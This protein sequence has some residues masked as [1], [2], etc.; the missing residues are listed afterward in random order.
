MRNDHAH[1]ARAVFAG[2]LL[3]LLPALAAPVAADYD[4]AGEGTAGYDTAY[5]Y[6]RVL[7]GSATLIQGAG[8]G[9]AAERA[10]AEIN[11]PV[12]AGDRL[13]VAPGS[14][15]EVLLSDRNLLRLDGESEAAFE[16]LAFSPES[17][18]RVTTLRLLRGNAQLVV[19]AD[20][21]GDQLPRFD[22]PNATIYPQDFGVYRVT[23][24]GGDWTEVVVRRGR[25]EVVTGPEAL[26]VSADQR[27]LVEGTGRPWTDVRAAGGYDPLERWAADLDRGAREY[28]S[29]YVDD[30]LRYAAGP[31]E[32]Y[33]RWV[34]VGGSSAWYPRVDAGWRPY[35]HGR[36]SHTPA[37][38]IWISS[39]PWGWVPYHYGTWDYAPGYGWVWFPGRRFA[40]AWVYWHWGS[41]HVAWVPVGYYT[42]HYRFNH[43]YPGFRSGVYGWAG[44]DWGFFSD[45]VFCDRVFFGGRHSSRHFFRGHDG[46]RR[47][48]GQAVP[49]GILTTDTRPLRPDLWRDGDEALRVL[50]TRP[51]SGGRVAVAEELPDVTPFV[52]RR[53]GDLPAEV[54][55]RIAI[56]RGEVDRVAGTPLAPGTQAPERGLAVPRA[57][58]PR[59]GVRSEGSGEVRRVDTDPGRALAV[60]RGEPRA[61][62]ARPKTE[63]GREPE[64]DRSGRDAGRAVAVPRGEAPRGE[65]PPGDEAGKPAPRAARPS[66]G[67][68]DGDKPQGEA[69]RAVRPRT[70]GS[71]DDNPQGAAPRAVRP[72]DGDGDDGK[73]RDE[74]SPRAAP[75]AANPGVVS[76]G[77][78]AVPRATAR[79][80]GQ[81][82]DGLARRAPRP[83]APATAGAG[84]SDAEL[85]RVPEAG[86]PASRPPAPTV[87]SSARRAPAPTARSDAPRSAPMV[88]PSERRA[89]APTVRPYVSRSAPT[90]QP[91]ERRAPAPTARPYVS[92][93][94]PTAQPP[95]SRAPAPTVRPTA[96]RTAPSARQPAARPPA[97]RASAP[98][99]GDGRT[100]APR[101]EAAPSRGES[102]GG[103]AARRDRGGS[104]GAARSRGDRG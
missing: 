50:R 94:A 97:P 38:L 17:G 1:D 27:A 54:E 43:G 85:R 29:P 7:D 78:T 86:R 70:G 90:V 57:A 15:A 4:A 24:D 77:R 88:Q 16:S 44:G 20:S 104:G 18:D 53:G 62:A 68:P 51:G 103:G 39:E 11:Q 82:G 10:Q 37:G 69:P 72:R 19:T 66:A 64:A 5:S 28:D 41:S 67:S 3:L 92:R 83:A 26:T 30:D 76:L 79:G 14:R 93:S 22:T 47:H 34:D 74:A 9:E 101:A 61:P 81:D 21:L 60:T 48:G 95:G 75:R 49:R 96:P 12:L 35:W 6:L 42:R 52:A 98:S 87:G 84:R 40:P 31:L 33:G 36:W 89:P 71:D 99:G 2:A 8:Y 46:R 45:W 32:R 65:T 56:T 55:R 59:E 58:V 102:R 80:G 63:G 73:P 91:S 100:A 13:W 25:A 23:T